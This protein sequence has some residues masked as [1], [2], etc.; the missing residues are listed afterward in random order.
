[1]EHV[2]YEWNMHNFSAYATCVYEINGVTTSNKYNDLHEWSL[3][4]TQRSLRAPP[5]GLTSAGHAQR[6]VCSRVVDHSAVAARANRVESLAC[7]Q[8]QALGMD[9]AASYIAEPSG[10]CLC[11]AT[12]IS[13]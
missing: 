7:A 11:L 10:E 9:A 3:A 12:L 4:E 1:M 8:K 5:Q 13:P 6:S 2:G